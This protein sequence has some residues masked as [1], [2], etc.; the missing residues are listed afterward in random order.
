MSS[1]L[2]FRG[3][4][5]IGLHIA[6]P[7]EEQAV[8]QNGGESP[9]RQSNTQPE[10]RNETFYPS[11]C[12]VLC[13]RNILEHLRFGGASQREGKGNDGPKDAAAARLPAELIDMIIDQAEYWP[14][15]E[16]SIDEPIVINQ[17]EDAELLRTRGLCY[18]VS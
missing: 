9:E 13:V 15:I 12:D 8:Y 2:R 6:D 10:K 18:A 16:T 1:W 7:E 3:P 5:N 17:D 11:L 14:S 4:R